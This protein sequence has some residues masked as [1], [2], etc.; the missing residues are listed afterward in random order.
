MSTISSYDVRIVVG[1]SRDAGQ[2][3]DWLRLQIDRMPNA[4]EV[5]TLHGTIVL[6]Y[7]NLEEANRLFEEDRKFVENMLEICPRRIRYLFPE[8]TKHIS[9]YQPD[10]SILESKTLNR[11]QVFS[12]GIDITFCLKD[13]WLLWVAQGNRM[14]WDDV[15]DFYHSIPDYPDADTSSIFWL[16][17]YMRDNNLSLVT[18]GWIKK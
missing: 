7:D 15:D 11:V 6:E 16:F 2:C 12:D 4:I 3:P 9:I 17:E 14:T 10:L 1:I 8:T 18:Y 5:D 13:L